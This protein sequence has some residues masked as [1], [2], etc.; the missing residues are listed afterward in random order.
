MI[1][2]IAVALWP[3]LIGSVYRTRPISFNGRSLGRKFHIILAMLPVFLMIALRH[4]MIGPDTN[5]YLTNFKFAVHAP[6]KTLMANSRMEDG[7]L[8]FVK[9][10][11]TYVTQD[12][13]VYQVI[14][15]AIY[16]VC[17]FI[18]MLDMEDHWPEFLFFFTTLG[19]FTFMF[20]GVRQCLAMSICLVA[21]RYARRKN[22]LLFALFVALAY[23]MHHSAILF[24]VVYIAARLRIKWYNILL[25][26]AAAIWAINNLGLL[27]EWFEETL[28]YDVE[29]E[30]G[31]GLVFLLF[32]SLLTI[33]AVFLLYSSK[34][35]NKNTAP[36]LTLGFFCLFFWILR[37]QTRV[38]ERPSYYFM[39]FACSGFAYAVN[40][41]EDTK[42]RSIVKWA[43]LG[44][45]LLLYVY[46]FMT[47]FSVYVPYS[48]FF[49]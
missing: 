25:Y 28:E 10:I 49:N 12:A 47:N 48:T 23:Q 5:G 42:Q 20:T 31:T 40:S 30:S 45:C 27:N 17:V 19:L 18:F 11:A 35:I 15:T 16:A 4:S 24:S 34:Q 43:C 8:A 9:F 21:Y 1:L 7:Y 29:L 32:L 41:V 3:L 44:L 46:R 6:L 39:F 38:A 13:N 2:Y 33:M 14:Y 37:L 26:V 36:L 22:I